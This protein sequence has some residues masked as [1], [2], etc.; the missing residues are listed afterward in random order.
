M[1][2]NRTSRRRT[3]SSNISPVFLLHEVLRKILT[4]I[5]TA[6]LVGEIAYIAAVLTYK[7]LYQ[8]RTS[9]VVSVKSDTSPVYSNLSA[10]KRLASSFSSF[11]DSDMMKKRIATEL[12][13]TE[14]EGTITSSVINETNILMMYVTAPN[15]RDAY[16]ITRAVLNNYQEFSSTIFSNI[17]LDV[18]QRPKIPTG[19]M[20]SSG[21]RRAA[22]RA[23]LAGAAAAIIIICV[24]AYMRD[25]VKT[26]S[27]V[28]RKLDTRMLAA[29]YHSKKNMTLRD[30]LLRRKTSI[31]ITDPLTGAG[32]LETIRKLRT[33]T[34]YLM[35]RNNAKVLMITS[36]AE[37]E[38]KSTIAANLALAFGGRDKNV[39]LMDG[40]LKKP[41]LHKILGQQ[42]KTYSSMA[43]LLAGRAKLNDAFVVDK[44]R[45]I[46]LLLGRRGVSNSSELI[47]GENMR[48]LIAQA[49]KSLDIII[50]DTPPMSV[51]TDA[52][53]IAELSDAAILV[54]QQDRTPA[55][56]INDTIDSINES[57]AKLLGCVFNNVR[58]AG[59][60]ETNAYGYGDSHYYE[61]YDYTRYG[62]ADTDEEYERTEPDSGMLKNDSRDMED[63]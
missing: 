42:S 52:E 53:Y 21:A 11:L 13:V 55:A 54:V 23:A 59:I 19:A 61:K 2:E 26:V 5:V 22:D 31:L 20:N 15:Q 63:A 49:R 48:A 39:L 34:E 46:M 37:N 44:K 32:F 51:S 8:T 47:S 3:A 25:T 28:E 35:R 38:G 60:G 9:F 58:A 56:V 62:N 45:R 1:D 57:N 29:V 43:D 36:V 24:L 33:R 12:G 27:D 18:L 30:R 6:A 40:D 4:V 41:A 50:I 16:L 10:A 14:I 17:V 7:P